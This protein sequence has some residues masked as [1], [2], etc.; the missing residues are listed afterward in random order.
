MLNRTLLILSLLWIFTFSIIYASTEQSP[1]I[2]LIVADDMGYG[3]IDHSTISIPNLQ[4]MVRGGVKFTQV[5]KS[6]RI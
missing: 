6:S 1:N 3:D 5:E 2:I 4:S